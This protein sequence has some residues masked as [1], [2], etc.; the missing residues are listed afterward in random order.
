MKRTVIGVL[1]F[2]M[3]A[4]FAGSAAFAQEKPAPADSAA[5][6]EKADESKS[7]KKDEKKEE[8]KKETYIKDKVKDHDVFQGLF[9]IYQNKEDGS[10]FLEIKKDQ[11]GKEYIYFNH[12]Q[13]GV[14]GS[15]FFRGQYRG[16]KIFSIQKHF[17]KI[18][19]VEENTSYYFDPENALHNAQ[20]ANIRSAPLAVLK[21]EAK[22]SLE[23]AYLV[24]ADGFF[25]GE[26]VEMIKPAYPRTWQGYKLGRLS[27][28]KTKLIGIRSYPQNTDVVVEYVYEDDSPEKSPGAGATDARVVS[29]RA[30]HSFIEVPKN[31]YKPR[32]DDPRVGYFMT[33]VTDL[34]STSA[35]PYRDLIHRWHLKKKNPGAAVSEPVEPIVWW[36]ENTTPKEIRGV[37]KDAVMSWNIAY[38][39]A[40]FK[41]A[42]V[43]K[44]QPDDADWDAG[45]IRYNVLRWTSSPNPPFG[46]YGPSFVN[47]RTGQILGAD[48]ML[49]Y[50]FITN[51]VNY[52]K[53]F[54]TALIEDEAAMPEFMLENFDHQYCTL[55]NHLHMNNMFGTTALSAFGKPYKEHKALIDE[56]IYYLLLHEVGHT[57]GL[58]HNMRASQ[59]N[60][61]TT[62]ANKN[63]TKK[64]GLTGSVM[65]YPAIN[66][67][68]NGQQQGQYYTTVPGPYDIW[69]IQFGYSP[70]L[71]DSKKMDAHLAKS[72]DPA[73]A[74]GNDADD[75]R[76]PGK[77]LD[78]RVNTGDMSSDAV[79]FALGQIQLSKEITGNLM[80][81]FKT[82]NQS[83]QELRDAYLISTGFHFNSLRVVSR[84]VGGVY[85]DRA[86]AG[87]P[88]ATKP[89]TPV[90]RADQKR[91][92]EALATYAFAPNAFD[93]PNN[94]YNY[95]QSQR[96][97]FNHFGAPEDPKIHSRVLAVQRGVLAHLLHQNVMERMSDTELYGNGYPLH[98]MM[99]DLT[100]A[101]FDADKSGSVNNFRK[102]LQVEYVNRLLAIMGEDGKSTYDH[103]SKGLAY[104]HLKN[105]HQMMTSASS[106]DSGTKAHRAYLAGMI[107]AQLKEM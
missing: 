92:M 66:F 7:D 13:D 105:I 102:G 26:E 70:E 53:I 9:T 75:M 29:V 6:A 58:N 106:P 93:S 99:D 72:T 107:D 68:T 30:Q 48:V 43:V 4:G 63:A 27:K 57:L 67:A 28:D 5:K 82:E 87:Q 22:D 86:Y 73:L 85:V 52:G 62:L 18:E 78:P 74:F 77:A 69:A 89:F 23:T 76:S 90:S 97:G 39:K 15:G 80:T 84:Y 35:T 104:Y 103:V 71:N 2:A 79:N 65:D 59:M 49:E 10:T 55:N 101:I 88:G 37:I 34:T 11:I 1:V 45:D 12:I 8:K 56:S 95:L 64:T 81:K 36:I 17:D 25:L 50:V 31:D 44:E 33:Q 24:K 40:G 51:R 41:N 83:Y 94:I 19:F 32:Y 91:A 46:G 20:T 96:R 54:D 60:D 100:A 42:V 21:V 16:S 3:L 61:M 38:E 14:V 47:P 98:E